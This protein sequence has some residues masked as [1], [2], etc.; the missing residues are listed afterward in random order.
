[1][2]SAVRGGTLTWERAQVAWELNRETLP[3]FEDRPLEQQNWALATW[4]TKK[5]IALIE[6]IESNK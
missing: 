4:R 6:M 1:M 3:E 5:K 2:R